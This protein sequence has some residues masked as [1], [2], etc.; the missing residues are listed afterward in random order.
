MRP[1][2]IMRLKAAMGDS[3]DKLAAAYGSGDPMA[4]GFVPKSVERKGTDADVQKSLLERQ[5]EARA[6]YVNPQAAKEPTPQQRAVTEAQRGVAT[7]QGMK[8]PVAPLHRVGGPVP[9]ADKST[10]RMIGGKPYRMNAAGSQWAQ[11]TEKTPG[12]AH[13]Y[14]EIPVG[15]A[16]ADMR[17]A[18]RKPAPERVGAHPE[19]LSPAKARTLT[20]MGGRVSQ[21]DKER[22]MR[23][24][25]PGISNLSDTANPANVALLELGGAGLGLGAQ[26]ARGLHAIGKPWLQPGATAA[27]AETVLG[28]GAGRAAEEVLGTGAG[29]GAM[30]ELE[31][32]RR[33][34]S[35]P[36]G[37]AIQPRPTNTIT[38]KD[39]DFARR[40]GSTEVMPAGTGLGAKSTRANLIAKAPTA[41]ERAQLAKAQGAAGDLAAKQEAWLQRVRAAKKPVDAVT[42]PKRGVWANIAEQKSGLRAAEGTKATAKVEAPA[43][44]KQRLDSEAR[45]VVSEPA[46]KPV[47]AI[48][49][50]AAKIR[51]EEAAAKSTGQPGVGK[52]PPVERPRNPQELLAE[53]RNMAA[54]GG[55][56]EAQVNRGAQAKKDYAD[57]Q[58]AQATYRE[59][60]K[61]TP[62][63]SP[64]IGQRIRQRT[65]KPTAKVPRTP[66][67]VATAKKGLID[68][69]G[70]FKKHPWGLRSRARWEATPNKKW[71]VTKALGK[72]TLVGGTAAAGV[73]GA[74]RAI[75]TQFD[76]KPSIL[77][78]PFSAIPVVGPTVGRNIGERVTGFTNFVKGVSGE[79][80]PGATSLPAEPFGAKGQSMDR[81]V[82]KTPQGGKVTTIAGGQ[83]SQLKDDKLRTPLPVVPPTNA[84][85]QPSP[86]PKLKS[87]RDPRIDA[88]WRS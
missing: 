76:V 42:P 15:S 74:G 61:G 78:R 36:T 88:A 2:V 26:A 86:A 38:P 81:T 67:E 34:R 77:T 30:R 66:E 47:S 39:I 37:T 83:N 84:S 24:K 29:G 25:Y 9:K 65:L 27:A 53:Q 55:K 35:R 56:T 5:R 58:A 85:Q 63:K 19:G 82:P 14:R 28:T 73:E 70:A 46:A 41:V 31:S 57:Q 22:F 3:F 20:E 33:L 49:D 11:I 62:I 17:P 8:A 40:V 75:E 43:A 12:A 21:A 60:T 18:L 6:Q 23:T 69:E 72:G 4:T 52:P 79:H 44:A 10:M 87:P 13:T 16:E 7:A 59:L 64:T 71:A 45:Q 1:I 48:D 80:K 50:M 51:A 54:R 32:L 68:A